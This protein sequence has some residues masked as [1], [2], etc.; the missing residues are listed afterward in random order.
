[1]SNHARFAVPALAATLALSLAACAGGPPRGGGP[2]GPD[3]EMRGAAYRQSVFLSGA[4]LL[5]VQFDKDGDYVTTR[6]EVE[7]G[8]AAEWPRAANGATTLSPIAFEAWAAKALGGPNIGPYRLAF[9]SNV[10]NE[11]TQIEFSNA[12]LAKFDFWDKDKDGRLTR[13]EM[14]ERLPEQRRPDSGPQQSGQMP[15]GRPPGGQRPR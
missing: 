11:I 1:M 10:N 13:A 15:G 5:F 3:D 4:S 6:A 9:D 7:A 8:A 14:T 2:G 12:I